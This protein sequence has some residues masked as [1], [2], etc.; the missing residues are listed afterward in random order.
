MTYE[1]FSFTTKIFVQSAIFFFFLGKKPLSYIHKVRPTFIKVTLVMSL[2]V[3]SRPSTK[4]QGGSGK[5]GETLRV[6]G[7][8]THVRFTG[9]TRCH[10]KSES[11]G[12][13]VLRD[14]S[15]FLLP[16]YLESEGSANGGLPGGKGRREEWTQYFPCRL[17]DG[18]P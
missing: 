7:R 14:E 9:E 18:L 5:T 11:V 2:S 8:T 3:G 1:Y 10:G 16:P 15:V 12:P 4:S 6:K 17:S 13:T